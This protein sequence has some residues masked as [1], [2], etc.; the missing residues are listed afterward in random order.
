MKICIIVVAF[1]LSGCAVKITTESFIYQ[2]K[3][4]EKKLEL[5]KINT[6]FE[7]DAAIATLS[8]IAIKTHDGAVLRGIEL[9]HKNAIGNLIFFGGNGM[10]ISSSSGI[11]SQ[12]AEIPV[13]VLWVDYRG[14]GVS[15]I[16]G[17]LSLSDFKNDA[18]YIFDYAE[19]SL[20]A[21][22]PMVIYGL[23][24]GSIIASYIASERSIDG[25]IL[26]GAISSVPELVD[27]LVP[28]WSKLFSTVEVSPE[29]ASLNSISLIKQYHNPV[30][31]LVGEEDET[32]PIKFSRALLEESPSAIKVLKVIPE[33]EHG[34][35]LK[36]Q[37]A[38]KTIQSFISNIAD[39]P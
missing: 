14:T 13:N 36:K 25:L 7:H 11:L 37:Q 4:I 22:V 39:L 15:E 5:A 34:E 29:L 32:T 3:I 38:I 21:D 33:A 28:I 1:F 26:D 17:R 2:D 10:K 6:K 18:I 35:T 23:S 12:F 24:M 19:Q 9:M 31:F 30:L 27:N 20:P 16:Q 8:E